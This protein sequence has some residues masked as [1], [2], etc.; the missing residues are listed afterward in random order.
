MIK[1]LVNFF[2]G[3]KKSKDD[4]P[5]ILQRGEGVFTIDQMRSVSNPC[6]CH[7]CQNYQSRGQ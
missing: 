6:R 4:R 1:K 3:Q 2:S 7:S 5:A